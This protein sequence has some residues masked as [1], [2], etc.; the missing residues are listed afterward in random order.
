M[1]ANSRVP[2]KYTCRAACFMGDA[3]G[4]QFS[5][6]FFSWGVAEQDGLRLSES[7]YAGLSLSSELRWVIRSESWA[8][9]LPEQAMC[10]E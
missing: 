8:L 5:V 3:L 4:G 6:G 10:D 7:Y 9:W 2:L 1:W